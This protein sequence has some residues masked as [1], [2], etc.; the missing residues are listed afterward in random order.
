[1]EFDRVCDS[2]HNYVCD[3][4]YKPGPVSWKCHIECRA[5]S[6]C[7]SNE[8]C[9][10]G[11]CICR[12]G[13]DRDLKGRCV[14]AYCVQNN[15]CYYNLQDYSTHCSRE[16]CVSDERYLIDPESQICGLMYR[17]VWYWAWVLVVL[18][19]IILT[20]CL[21]RIEKQTQ[22]AIERRRA[23]TFNFISSTVPVLRISYLL[24]F[25]I[26]CYLFDIMFLIF[27]CQ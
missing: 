15:D 21:F 18:P 11:V 2:D 16:T 26:K 12:S 6:Q 1:M 10:H 17:R 7:Q 24:I 8:V 25:L 3:T 5:S 27:Y 4:G 23:S 9:F 13:F 14:S 19:P 20:I 22:L